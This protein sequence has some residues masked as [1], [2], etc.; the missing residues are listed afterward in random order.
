PQKIKEIKAA[1]TA[2]S[3]R[4]KSGA[5]ST[6]AKSRAKSF[7]KPNKPVEPPGTSIIMKR[8]E[9][10]TQIEGIRVI[11]IGD[12]HE[13][14][15]LD[16]SVK[17]FD[18]NVRD[19]TG[20]MNVDTQMDMFINVYNFSK[21]AWEPLIEPW[22]LG[23]HMAKQQDP[24]V[25]SMELYSHKQMDMTITSATIA[26]ASKSF[27]FL[28]S[29]EDILSKPRVQDAPYRIRNYTGFDLSIWADEKS[30]SAA[31]DKL[32]D[33]EEKPWRFEDAVSMRKNLTPEGNA[34]L[35]GIKIEGSGF[36]SIGR[37]QV[38][39]EGETLYNLKPRK[40]KVQHR[41]LVE[42]KLGT[43]N[44]KYITF[45]SPLLAENR[46]QIPIEL[47]VFSPEEG[48]LL[49]IEKIPPGEAKPAPIG[50]CFVH[51][52]LIRPDQGFG[53]SWSDERVF[54]K[55][56]IDKP[57]RTITCRSENRDQSPPFFF[58]LNAAYDHKDPMV[59]IYPYMRLQISAPVEVQNLLPYDLN[60][61]LEDTEYK[62]SDFAIINS[63][64][65]EDFR[66]EKEFTL[67]DNQ[68][69]SLRLK[70]HYTNIKDSGGAFRVSIYS[71]YVILNKTGLDMSVQS[72][73]SMF[74][75]G[76][77][78]TTQGMQARSAGRQ[79]KAL[80]YLYSYPTDDQK[81]RSVLKIGD[82]SWS[83]AQSFDAIGSTY[84]VVLPAANAKAEFHA[85]VYVT[86]GEGKYNLT[87]V[88]TVAPRFVVKN[89]IGETV[90]L[91]EPGS[92]D[93]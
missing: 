85:G 86:E 45:R 46:T 37:I 11:L 51:S 21:S 5:A 50:A 16:F 31:A 52:L 78:S 35:V 41:M 43:D 3:A 20:P 28:T 14:P 53:Y 44:V 91:R 77:S 17:K 68:N 25:T 29:N 71:P 55:N 42:I 4:R 8:E 82:S 92:A 49:K 30:D 61:E 79:H 76:K 57:T 24:E 89:K 33:G 90:E 80:P 34:G 70:L 59:K 62:Q 88:V 1:N 22:Q 13:L 47:G 65:R 84:E 58:Q 19:W 69:G 7:S 73:A 32:T 64:T 18:V 39:R 9:L 87:K 54:W 23:F 93:T 83:K 81:N 63:H 27:D 36:D 67:K 72:K 15:L 66:R 10:T 38:S 40:D 12:L 74:G 56:L 6:I 60:V 26:L 2:P 48:D 75:G